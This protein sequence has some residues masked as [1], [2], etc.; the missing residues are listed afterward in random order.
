MYYVYS[1][2]PYMYISITYIGYIYIYGTM[3]YRCLKTILGIQSGNTGN[4][5]YNIKYNRTNRDEV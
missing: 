1:H 4:I 3:I 5:Q 2:I